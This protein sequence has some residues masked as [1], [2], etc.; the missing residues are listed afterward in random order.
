ME[1]FLRKYGVVL[2]LYLVIIG[3]ILLLNARCKMLNEGN[4]AE[5]VETNR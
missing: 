3:G 5:I 1:K 4:D 2:L